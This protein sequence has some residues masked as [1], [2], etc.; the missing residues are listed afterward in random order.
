MASRVLECS[1]WRYMWSAC[2]LP[3]GTATEILVH[4]SATG[5][6]RGRERRR[7]ESSSGDGNGDGIEGGIGEGGRE[8]KKRK[9]P[10]K[11]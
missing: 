4:F 1:P 11:S 6:E 2:S 10:H 8:A 7:N 3:G 5:W 9:K